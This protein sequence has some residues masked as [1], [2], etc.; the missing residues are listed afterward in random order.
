MTK[1]FPVFQFQS[2]KEI[3]WLT[4][5]LFHY[6]SFF[7]SFLPILSDCNKFQL[8]LRFFFVWRQ[9]TAITRI[10]IYT[11]HFYYAIINNF[12]MH[13]FLLPL[14]HLMLLLLMLPTSWAYIKMTLALLW[15]IAQNRLHVWTIKLY[16][17]YSH[18]VRFFSS[19]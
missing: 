8:N 14:N 6:Y 17:F 4:P 7:L 2:K 18:D 1:M 15:T 13:F 19:I 3:K 5:L 16:N 12:D 9:A 10:T 11:F